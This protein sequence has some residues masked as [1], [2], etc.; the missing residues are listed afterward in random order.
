MSSVQSSRQVAEQIVESFFRPLLPL[1][2]PESRT[3]ELKVAIADALARANRE[4]WEAAAQIADG[5][6]ER[7]KGDGS[8][9]NLLRKMG[10]DTASEIR[11][12]ATQ[13]RP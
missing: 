8:L 5:Y 4:T 12:R 9:R 2:K 10:H 11:R 7:I 3:T 1:R 6:A 13:E